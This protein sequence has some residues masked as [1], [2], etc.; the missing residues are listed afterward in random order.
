MQKR[1]CANIRVFEYVFT[2]SSYNSFKKKIAFT[3]LG[4]TILRNRL[5][6]QGPVLLYVKTTDH[7]IKGP[8][9][10]NK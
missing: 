8:E 5:D 1:G 3:L 4:S 9:F 10:M 7:K 6:K 2:S